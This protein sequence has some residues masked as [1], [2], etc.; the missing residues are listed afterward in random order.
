MTVS[1]R[2][3]ELQVDP[4]E[5]CVIKHAVEEEGGSITF[6]HLD[7]P[8]GLKT[9]GPDD[10]DVIVALHRTGL[11]DARRWL[12]RRRV[13]AGPPVIV[14]TEEDSLEHYKQLRRLG[15]F[16][17]VPR[18][19]PAC[20][21]QAVRLA[22]DSSILDPSPGRASEPPSE[23]EHRR[24]AGLMRVIGHNLRDLLGVITNAVEVLSFQNVPGSLSQQ[25]TIELLDRQCQR[26]AGLL[27]DYSEIARIESGEAPEVVEVVELG[28][29]LGRAIR[30][31]QQEARDEQVDFDRV[32]RADPLWLRT[33][34][35]RLE[36]LVRHSLHYCRRACKDCEL[37]RVDWRQASDR[38]ELVFE[39][40]PE[41]TNFE[42]PRSE[43]S[44]D[45]DLFLASIF[46]DRLGGL[47]RPG[48]SFVIE[49][50]QTI[51]AEL[52]PSEVNAPPLRTRTP[53]R[54]GS[55][56][57]VL[58]VD[59]N[60]ESIQALG[61]LIGR[62]GWHVRATPRIDEARE[63]IQAFRPQVVLIGLH[64]PFIEGHTLARRIRHDVVMDA[65][66]LIGISSSS[67]PPVTDP[68][69]ERAFDHIVTKPVRLAELAALLGPAGP[70]AQE[71]SSG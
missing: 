19:H 22:A 32:A 10:A 47:L 34:A 31:A 44:I 11:S 70:Q 6:R 41:A 53:Q 55:A 67:S 45:L 39:L 58:L 63:M 42:V 36:H 12:P 4:D 14:I 61:L 37:I 3:T 24:M 17:V 13:G 8:T 35:K 2:L 54:P 27:D 65:P 26:M 57:H 18:G 50:P 7:C 51:V 25:R 38:L 21:I 71:A 30:R 62:L 66:L 33:D 48:P 1:L 52:G 56:G 59:D 69:G 49:L 9:I 43:K 5:L 28:G 20:L 64:M 16:A 68:E 40:L 23:S 15:A 29:L 46:A 60:L